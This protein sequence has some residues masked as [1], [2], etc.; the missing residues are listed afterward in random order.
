MTGGRLRVVIFG[1]AGLVSIAACRALGRAH[2]VRCII[3]PKPAADAGGLRGRVRGALNRLRGH[4]DPLEQAAR[5]AGAKICTI[6]SGKDP[7]LVT[8]VAEARPDLICV[9]HFPWRIPDAALAVP[10]LG[11]INL[12]PSLLPRHRGPLPL[13]W[14]YQADD[15]VTGVTVHVLTSEFD[16]GDIIVQRQFPLPRGFPVDS[17][18]ARNAEEGALAL[19]EAVARLASGTD[20]R[21]PQDDALATHAPRVKPGQSLVDF[22]AWDAERVW[23]FLAGL[24]PRF[25]EPLAGADGGR[26][27]YDGVLGYETGAQSGAPGTAVKG[28]GGRLALQCRDG[29]VWLAAGR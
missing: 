24:Y 2:D 19:T 22:A 28:P 1:T 7:R 11:G 4:G 29:V 20:T 3:R 16:A 26:I 21:H 17:L 8:A 6:S 23:H 10:R 14:I 9:A 27:E 13:C 12:H 25:R 18:N 15:R 5:D